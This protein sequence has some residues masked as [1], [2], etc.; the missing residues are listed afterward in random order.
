VC[1]LPQYAALL[2]CSLPY[3]AGARIAPPHDSRI[4]EHS[5]M[6]LC[7]SA[8]YQFTRLFFQQN[9]FFSL[10]TERLSVSRKHALGAPTSFFVPAF[11]FSRGRTLFAPTRLRARGTPRYSIFSFLFSFQCARYTVCYQSA[12]NNDK[13]LTR[14]FSHH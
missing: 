14:L 5:F 4:S 1:R 9:F 6:N 3:T 8:H 2:I 12:I 10:S 7:A 13:R 11:R